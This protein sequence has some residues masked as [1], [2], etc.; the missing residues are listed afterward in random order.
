M[1]TWMMATHGW[2]IAQATAG[3]CNACGMD[4][5]KTAADEPARHDLQLPAFT[6][7]VSFEA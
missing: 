3:P 1:N 2:V 6:C 4:T 5:A 7:F